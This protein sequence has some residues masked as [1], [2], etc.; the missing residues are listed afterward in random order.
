MMGLST[1]PACVSIGGVVTPRY[2]WANA[3]SCRTGMLWQ[4]LAVCFAAGASAWEPGRMHQSSPQQQE[5]GATS[6]MSFSEAE[7][8]LHIR[9]MLRAQEE[10]DRLRET[11]RS[12]REISAIRQILSGLRSPPPA[13]PA[14]P[15][16]PRHETHEVTLLSFLT[17]GVVE[18][19]D[20]FRL[21][22]VSNTTVA[23]CML[24]SSHDA[25]AHCGRWACL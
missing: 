11:M 5:S 4:L 8:V 17:S 22:R 15:P 18:D 3:A 25:L 20:S 21:D 6:A 12:I 9:S 23:F 24:P 19:Y 14:P 13:A 10:E 1:K 16:A 2:Q 7:D